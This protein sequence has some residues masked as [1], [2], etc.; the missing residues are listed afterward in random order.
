[1]VFGAHPEDFPVR[2]IGRSAATGEVS[3]RRS[4]DRS[5]VP[6]FHRISAWPSARCAQTAP[7]LSRSRSEVAN[8]SRLNGRML[9]SSSFVRRC[10]FLLGPVAFLATLPP[11]VLFISA[12]AAAQGTH[13]WT[14]SQ[15]EE[16]EKGTP[17]GVSIESDGHLRQGPGLTELV[18]TPS[19]FVWSLAA[20]KMGHV[21]A[22]T[23]SP[24]TVLRL[25]EKPGEKPFTLFETR[26]LSVQALAI[27]PDGSL[28]AA[29]VP[30]GRVYKLNPDATTKL[31]ES[32]APVVFDASKADDAAGNSKPASYSSA[33]SRYIWDLTFDSSGRLYIATGNPGAVYRVDPNKPGAAPELFFKSDEAHIRALAW[34][35]KGNLIAGSDGSGL[36]YRIDPHGKGYVL[37]ESPRR[38][39]TS[40]AVERQRNHLRSLRGRQEPQ[41]AA[42]ASG[43]GNRRGHRHRGSTAIA[44]G[45]QRQ[46]LS[47]RGDGDLCSGGG[48]GAAQTLVRQGRDR[49]RVGRPPRR[50]PRAQ[51]QSRA[52]LSHRGRRQLRRHWL[53]CRR[54]RA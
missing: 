23:G 25:G 39:I 12:T 51:R 19:T 37:F 32:N 8:S 47:A 40:L 41:S 10:L 54:S 24:A 7:V 29:T 4:K 46:R 13:L 3:K 1:M 15:M 27:G 26:D 36:V 33:Q 52:N 53:I 45:S 22:G 28:Y 38:E 50:P 11:A 43:A 49:L 18:T 42:P 31:D 5:F 34:D 6:V 44:A 48:P 30:G 35:A 20:D 16:F 2:S 9:A 17:A 14:Q 21:F